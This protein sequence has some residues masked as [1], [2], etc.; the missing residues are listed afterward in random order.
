MCPCVCRSTMLPG[1]GVHG[2]TVMTEA[3]AGDESGKK[4]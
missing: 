2:E 3:Y 1:R 4:P